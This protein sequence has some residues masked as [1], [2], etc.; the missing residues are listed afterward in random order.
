MAKDIYTDVR[1]GAVDASGGIDRD[2]TGLVTMSLIPGG[3]NGGGGTLTNSLP[4]TLEKQ[5]VR[6]E[7]LFTPTFSEACTACVLQFVYSNPNYAVLRLTPIKVTTK[8]IRL[9]FTIAPP[10]S[11]AP[12]EQFSVSVQ[13]VDAMG[14][15]DETGRSTISMKHIPDSTNGNGGSLLNDL[16]SSREAVSSVDGVSTFKPSFTESCGGCRLQFSDTGTTLPVLSSE[17]IQVSAAV[18]RWDKVTKKSGDSTNCSNRG[19]LQQFIKK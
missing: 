5:L 9:T 13:A 8:A 2:E 17:P 11:V 1:I 12:N 15:R 16:G 6:G 10:L 18:C 4:P 7:V 14:N 19:K 3:G